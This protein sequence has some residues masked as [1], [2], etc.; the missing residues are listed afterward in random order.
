MKKLLNSPDRVLLAFVL[1]ILLPALVYAWAVRPN[2][3]ATGPSGL[4]AGQNIKVDSTGTKFEST[5]AGG[6]ETDAIALAALTAQTDIITS[7]GTNFIKSGVTPEYVNTLTADAQYQL[8]NKQPLDAQLTDLAD[9]TISGDFVNTAYPWLMEEILS[10]ET[11]ANRIRILPSMTGKAGFFLRA[12]ADTSDYEL[13]DTITIS[14]LTIPLSTTTAG[15]TDSVATLRFDP[16]ASQLISG[17]SDTNVS[18]VTEAVVG[19]VTEFV[20][21]TVTGVTNVDS[22]DDDHYLL[23][24]PYNI[25]IKQISAIQRRNAGSTAAGVPTTINIQECTS[26][27]SCTDMITTDWILSGSTTAWVRK[28]VGDFSDSVG[29]RGNSLK[30]DIVSGASNSDLTVTIMYWINRE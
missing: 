4:T 13:T 19:G 7:G 2:D 6:A 8:D 11:V 23:D 25:T 26:A 30:L 14:G 12:K 15:V 3:L 18:G 20:S 1:V 17:V 29:T 5:A 22:P 28:G 9:G 16:T 24:L 27:L 21:F 10:G